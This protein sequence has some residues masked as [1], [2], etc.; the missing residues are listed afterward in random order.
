[1]TVLRQ[2]MHED[3]RV[4]NY[5]P[6]TQQTYI[7]RVAKFARH[8]RRSPD[9]LGPEEIRA[10]Q[11]YQLGVDLVLSVAASSPQPTGVPGQDRYKIL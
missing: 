9:L 3:L 7:D 10:Y 11:L 1:M 5:S 4:R 2:R 8:F 6:R